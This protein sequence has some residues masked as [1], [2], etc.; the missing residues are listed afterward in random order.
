MLAVNFDIWI[1]LANE[2]SDWNTQSYVGQTRKNFLGGLN[3]YWKQTAYQMQD[4]VYVKKQFFLY[5]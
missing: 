1:I 4:C 3:Y 5:K 2:L